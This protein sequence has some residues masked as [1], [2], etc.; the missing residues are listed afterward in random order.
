M[1]DFSS[2]QARI[3]KLERQSGVQRN[4]IVALIALV[5]IAGTVAGTRAQQQAVSFTDANGKTRVTLDANGLV[6]NGPDGS[7]RLAIGAYTD[8]DPY[9][10]VFDAGTTATSDN[11]RIYLGYSSTESPVFMLNAAN[12]K[13]LI[14]S[15]AGTYP[16]T[17]FYDSNGNKRLFEGLTTDASGLTVTMYSA[18]G[19]P[20]IEV[21]GQDLAGIDVHQADGTLRGYF[22]IASDGSSVMK[23]FSRS[24]I[25][26]L[27]AGEYSDNSSGVTTYNTA[28]AATWNSR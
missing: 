7:K 3:E 12:G 4:L 23:L 2:L 17:Y 13:P 18:S 5:A 6:L 21:T 15:T 10:S 8:G 16:A 11:R 14:E 24:G 28:G 26:R 1:S 20:T 27:F 25:E 9:I 22:G 19:Q